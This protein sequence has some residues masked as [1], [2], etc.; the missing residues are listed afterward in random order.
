MSSE[1]ISA[2]MVHVA[3]IS[4]GLE[5]F[6]RAFP[7]AQ[8]MRVENSDFEFLAIDSIRLEIVRADE[9]V[10]AGACGSIVYW[11][12]SDLDATVRHMES[13]G[14]ALYRGPI[15]IEGRLSMCQVRDPWGNCIGVR[16]P[17]TARPHV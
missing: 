9:K 5:W 10:S 13:I 14:A 6:G 3:D 7:N 2:V 11:R 12:V 15:K 17:S 1:L 4:A 8:R 16:G